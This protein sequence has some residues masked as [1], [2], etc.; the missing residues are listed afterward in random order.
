MDSQKSHHTI[1]TFIAATNNEINEEI[2]HIKPP[3]SSNFSEGEPKALED[4]QERDHVATVYANKGGAATIMDVTDYIEKA[5]RQLN[6][7]EHYRQLSKDQAVANN[8]TVNNVIEKFQKE[9]LITKNVAE[10]LKTTSSRTPRFHIQP[11]L[12]KQGNPEIPVI[13]SLNC[14]TS[15]ISKYLVYHLQPILKQTPPYIQDTNNF[16]RKINKTEKIP[17]NSYLVSLDERS[18]YTSIPNSKVVKL[19]KHL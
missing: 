17:E 16:L 15:N 9:N 10:G 1:E 8:E 19:P 12:H 6:E 7:K 18:L 11:K 5:E 3:K 2:A 14:H 4:L 13:S